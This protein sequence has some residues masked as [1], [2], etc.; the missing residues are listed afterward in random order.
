MK[1][2]NA[3]LT[4]AL[5]IVAT[6]NI[7]ASPNDEDAIKQTLESYVSSVD[8]KDSDKLEDVF[9]KDATLIGMNNIT[10]KMTELSD[11]ALIAQVKNGMVGGWKRNLKIHSID[12]SGST[13]M[14]KIEVSD[15]KLKQIE[16]VTLIKVD[17]SW[18]I[19]NSTF[20][21]EKI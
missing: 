2:L 7:N 13:A 14:A 9:F 6:F 3:L 5:I 1:L 8:Q 12:V 21:L 4:F 17:E 20:T 11:D 16:Y 19:V 10:K 15:A 18:K